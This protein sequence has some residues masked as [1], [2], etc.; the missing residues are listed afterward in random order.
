[1]AANALP[2]TRSAGGEVTP[3]AQ[4]WALS[5]LL[6]HLNRTVDHLFGFELE[7]AELLRLAE[8]QPPGLG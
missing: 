4:G 6:S 1:M 3:Q 2:R 7:A 5:C 8:P